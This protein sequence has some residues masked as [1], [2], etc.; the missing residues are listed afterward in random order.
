M[1]TKAGM[2]DLISDYLGDLNVAS[3]PYASPL[4]AP[5]LSGLPPALI[6]TCEYDP[7]CDDGEAYG[8]R[9]QEAGVPA[10]VRCWPGMI[11][12]AGAMTAILPSARDYRAVVIDALRH[13]L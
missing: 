11:H 10:T 3:E 2:R 8:R 12:G 5:D 13:A 9:L 6:M 4:L 1:L 7:L